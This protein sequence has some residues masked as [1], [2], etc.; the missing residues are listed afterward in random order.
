MNDK[1]RQFLQH[2]AAGTVLAAAPAA[3]V[4]PARDSRRLAAAPDLPQRQAL[5]TIGL[6]GEWRLGCNTALGVL[7][8]VGAAD[9]MTIPVPSTVDELFAFGGGAAVDHVVSR[10]LADPRMRR[11]FHDPAR[12][13]FGPCVVRPQK[14]IMVGLNY[15]RHAEEVGAKLPE[16]PLLFNKFGNALLGHQGVLTLPRAVAREFDH[17]VELVIVIGRRAAAVSEAA[18]LSHVAGYCTGND[19]SARDLQRVTSQF[20]LGKSCDGFAPLG[21]WL[22]TADLVPDPNALALWCDVNGERRQSS[23]TADMVFNC[24][25]LVSYV[26][27]HMTLEPGD[28]IFTGTPEGV[29]AGRPEGSRVWL[30][31]GDTV[32]CGIEKLGEQTITLA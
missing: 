23:N 11:F 15:R 4:A 8:V 28:L 30:K 22:L 10:A 6:A 12:T 31:P 18:A 1:R 16:T 14:I 19:F 7:D 26:S 25:Q 17:E 9:D 24:A 13:L 32:T 27:R 21:P 20:M 29:I 3:A 2:A 5:A